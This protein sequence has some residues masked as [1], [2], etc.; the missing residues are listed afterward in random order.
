[1]LATY[2]YSTNSR[3]DNLEP[4][5]RYLTASTGINVTV[6]SYPTVQ[7]LIDAIRRREVHLAMI[8]TLGYL[9]LQKKY[10]GAAIPLVTLDLGNEQMTNYGGCLLTLRSSGLTSIDNIKQRDSFTVLA[11]VNNAST[12]G[13][14]VPRLLLNSNGIPEAEK[15][16]KLYY[17]GTHK[18]VIDDLLSGKA[19]IGGCGCAEYDKNLATGKDFTDKVVK[20]ASFDNIPLGPVIYQPSLATASVNKIRAALLRV[21]QQKPEAFRAF[22]AGWTE[23]LAAKKFRIAKDADYNEFR[24]LFGTNE[25]L[26]KLLD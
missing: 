15:H 10:P 12:S 21:H 13:N 2:A 9:S 14:L 24:S 22:C 19:T 7:L 5:A 6:K 26:W 20:I 17:A 8:N 1:M 25:S 4:L 23:F 16:F 18:Q 11:L 3:I